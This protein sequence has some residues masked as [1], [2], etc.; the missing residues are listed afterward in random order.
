MLLAATLL[1]YRPVVPRGMDAAPE[2]FSAARALGEL[3]ELVGN[4]DSHPIGS[5]ANARV[6]GLIVKRL[7]SLG[8]RTELQ[9]GLV[10]N[11]G[12]V[13]GVPTNII[14]TFGEAEGNDALLLAAHYD[15]VP[16]GPGASD[17]G[18]GV[19]A[20]LEIARILQVRPKPRHALVLLVTD[21][22]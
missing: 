12:G 9:S 2:T 4:D 18:V 5:P 21:G 13:C 10:C 8:Y 3:R 22:E 6:R 16:A 17:D 1:A 14:A 15:S 19:G 7:E 11:D 20:V